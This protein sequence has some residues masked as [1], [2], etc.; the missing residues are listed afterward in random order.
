VTT[1]FLVRHAAHD[2]LGL[3]LA[4]RLVDPSLGEDGRAQA[5]RLAERMRRERFEAIH[6]SPRKRTRETAARIA[7]TVDLTEEVEPDLDEIDF[8]ADW[9][10]RTFDEL[11][12]DPRWREWNR[13]RAAAKTPTGESLAD[14]QERVCRHMRC[15]SA[16]T[17]ERAVVLVSHA[18]VI[19]AAVA[20]QI[21]LPLAA[22]DRLEIAPASVTTLVV[23]DWG[24]KLIGLNEVVV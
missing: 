1:F 10:G 14:V 20:G 3:Y 21:G 12:G 13:D 22:I 8:G 15:L 16:G 23:G 17:R 24:A 19:K 18:D 4:G 11:A 6:T 2:N 5:K 9:C 7:A